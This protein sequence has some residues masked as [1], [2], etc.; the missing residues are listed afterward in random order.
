VNLTRI[1]LG[2]AV[3]LVTVVSSTLFSS[4]RATAVVTRPA[5]GTTLQ[6]AALSTVAG[7]GRHTAG[8]RGGRRVLVT[9]RK[10]SGLGSLRHAL[11]H[12]GGHRIV[13]FRVA[14]V[15][16]L[17]TPI[18]IK[19]PYITVKGGS[20]PRGG[21]EIRGNPILVVTHD[22]ILKNLRLRPGDA[23]MSSSEAGQADG[24]TVNGVGGNVYNVVLDHLSLLWGPDIGGLAVLGNVHDMTVQY[25]IMGEG[26]RYSRHPE[27]APS[28]DGHSMAVNLAPLSSSSLAPHR[29][30]FY[31][32]LFT[33]SNARMPRLEGVSCVDLVNNVIYNW[34]QHA[35][36]G[37]PRS[38]NIVNNWFRMGP[39]K[40]TH[41]W[42]LPQTSGDLPKKFRD[43]VYTHGNHRDGF[44]G[45]RAPDSVVYAGTPRCGGVSKRPWPVNTVFFSVLSNV[46]ARMPT[47]DSVDRRV[48]RNVRQR[49]GK[50]FNGVGFPA[51]NP[52]W[53][54]L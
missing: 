5:T 2:F 40:G 6:A 22:V 31:R 21:V 43:S 18:R 11:E 32:N 44:R 9:N 52:Y 24:L 8:G 17:Q 23:M 20:A 10:D 36:T 51:P 37:N 26:L 47:L 39:H 41:D 4:P 25:T 15:I 38:A 1:M 42:W 16:A 28:G 29:I 53:P 19:H 3:G 35:G 46:G 7:Y 48:I 30:T 45:G 49:D 27:A 13:R 12:A 34:G 50:Y 54:S 33:T 14:G